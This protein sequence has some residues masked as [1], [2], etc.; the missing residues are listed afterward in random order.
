[1]AVPEI[2]ECP[3]CGSENEIGAEK[4][5]KPYCGASLTGN[6]FSELK[7]LKSIDKSLKAIKA[8]AVFWLVLIIIGLVAYLII[9]SDPLSN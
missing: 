5:A 9:R 7:Y 4:C 8:I 6:D 2:I 1:M 3:S